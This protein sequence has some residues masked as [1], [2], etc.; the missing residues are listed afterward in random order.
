MLDV[1]GFEDDGNL[2]GVEVRLQ[3]L[4]SLTAAVQ[5]MTGKML[6][7]NARL[8]GSQLQEARLDGATFV[9]GT[10]VMTNFGGA[11]MPDDMQETDFTRAT[12]NS[13]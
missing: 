13:A 2:H 5:M 12:L 9:Q 3:V 4:T 1:E 8:D 10:A 11:V 6:L 7:N